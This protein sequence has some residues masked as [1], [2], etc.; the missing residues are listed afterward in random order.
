MVPK[1]PPYRLKLPPGVNSLLV[2]RLTTPA[3]RSPYWA[4]SA[5]SSR[6][7]FPM[8]PVSNTGPLKKHFV[9]WRVV[10]L[11]KRLNRLAIHIVG[12]GAKLRQQKIVTRLIHGIHL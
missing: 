4:G 1:L 2:V 6:F 12:G 3:V 9:D 5:P 7:K 11:R 10:A 8:K